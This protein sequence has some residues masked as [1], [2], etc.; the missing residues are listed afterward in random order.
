MTRTITV[1]VVLIIATSVVLGSSAD[2]FAAP[3][4]TVS[5][6]MSPF[7]IQEVIEKAAPGQ[8]IIFS[9]GT[10]RLRQ[11][12][13]V[14]NKN[15]LTLRA[16]GAV[17]LICNSRYDNVISIHNSKFV[18]LI[19]LHLTHLNPGD[20][21]TCVGHVVFV[22]SSLRTTIRNCDLDGC[23]AIGIYAY[24]NDVRVSHTHIHSCSVR[25]IEFEGESL[26]LR[27]C[28]LQNR[29]EDDLIAFTHQ[30]GESKSRQVTIG[31]DDPGK[32]APHGLRMNYC[33]LGNQPPRQPKP[34]AGGTRGR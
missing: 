22:S 18:E 3:P 9:P 21:S 27:H 6:K 28:H 10:Y 16:K 12:L 14:R 26:T 30:A 2:A 31:I 24:T 8:T 15:G 20:G 33:T 29:A 34:P 25:P 23:G 1:A 4:I 7:E 13:I 5:S 11:S 19:G 32:K 17:T